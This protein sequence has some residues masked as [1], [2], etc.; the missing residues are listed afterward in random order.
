[1]RLDLLLRFVMWVLPII[2]ALTA[3]APS[4]PWRHCHNLGFAIAAYALRLIPF[5]HSKGLC[6]VGKPIRRLKDSKSNP[7][8]PRH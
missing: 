2:Q 5:R 4:S 1:M 6:S 8:R 7:H 3:P